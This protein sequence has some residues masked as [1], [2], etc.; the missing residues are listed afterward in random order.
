MFPPHTRHTERVKLKPSC[1]IS[2]CLYCT[3]AQDL[4]A[5]FLERSSR[6]RDRRLMVPD[7]SLFGGSTFGVAPAGQDAQV[8]RAPGLD[9]TLGHYIWA[10][11]GTTPSSA[12]QAVCL[13]W[14][15]LKGYRAEEKYLLCLEGSLGRKQSEC[16]CS[17]LPVPK[18][19]SGPST[20]L[21]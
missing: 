19:A 11:H 21:F 17:V 4:R 1:S 3:I 8:C 18:P 10:L 20:T 7:R 13:S 9:F 6:F 15:F 12:G 5:P 2:E 14:E 16:D